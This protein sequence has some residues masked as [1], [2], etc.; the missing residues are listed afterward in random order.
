[1]LKNPIEFPFKA[2]DHAYRTNFDGLE[3]AE[4]HLESKLQTDKQA[5]ED[6]LENFESK[7]SKARNEYKSEKDEGFT[8]SSFEDWVPRNVSSSH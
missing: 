2:S 1:M 4:K 3:I 5:F 6:A 8:T 7:D